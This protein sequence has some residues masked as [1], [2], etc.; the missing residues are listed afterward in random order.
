MRN[1]NAITG[2][3]VDLSQTIYNIDDFMDRLVETQKA[4]GQEPTIDL[5][6]RNLY[7]GQRYKKFQKLSPEEQEEYEYAKSG[8]IASMD[9]DRISE[10][11]DDPMEGIYVCEY[12]AKL[13]CKHGMD[14][15]R[16]DPSVCD[17]CREC[18]ECPEFSEYLCSGCSYSIFRE[19][20]PYGETLN[21][22]DVLSDHDRKIFDWVKERMSEPDRKLDDRPKYDDTYS[23]IDY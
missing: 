16:Y 12:C 18:E 7:T 11:G 22:S 8:S 10:D 20:V 3:Q 1:N 17:E 21:S 15:P 9:P 23:I 14:I 13:K 2:Q 4:H 5:A 6:V 19:G